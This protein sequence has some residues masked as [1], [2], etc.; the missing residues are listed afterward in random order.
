MDAYNREENANSPHSDG[1][2]R[3]LDVVHWWNDCSHLRKRRVIRV[4]RKDLLRFTI[5]EHATVSCVMIF[6]VVRWRL[7]NTGCL[8]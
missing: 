6:Q 8:D 5:V 7:L 2:Y 3:Q 4:V 1:V